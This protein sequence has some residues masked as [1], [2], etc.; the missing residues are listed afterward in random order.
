MRLREHRS[1]ASPELLRVPD[2][3][4]LYRFLERLDDPTIDR[5]LGEAAG[6]IKSR[7]RRSPVLCACA[8]RRDRGEARTLRAPLHSPHRAAAARNYVPA[9]IGRSGQSLPILDKLIDPGAVRGRVA[10]AGPIVGARPIR[11]CRPAEFS[12]DWACSRPMLNRAPKENH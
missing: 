8:R 9:V 10:P 2:Y 3:T 1:R 12:P 7:K 5:V 4:T 6:S 11:R